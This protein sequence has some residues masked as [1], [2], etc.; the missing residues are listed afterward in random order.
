MDQMAQKSMKAKEEGVSDH[1]WPSVTL[2]TVR[3]ML[4]YTVELAMHL[5]GRLTVSGE[6]EL[7]DEE[8]GEDAVDDGDDTLHC[9]RL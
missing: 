5:Q 9:R 3:E 8:D 6:A 7:N 1:Q 4:V 2:T